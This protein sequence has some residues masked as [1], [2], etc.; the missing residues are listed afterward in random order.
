MEVLMPW[1][2]GTH[3]KHQIVQIVCDANWYGRTYIHVTGVLDIFEFQG[4]QNDEEARALEIDTFLV[5]Q[6]LTSLV[7]QKQFWSSKKL[8]K[9]FVSYS[10][11]KVSVI[12]FAR[13]I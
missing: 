2:T 3:P 11:P 10:T 8:K 1:C 13:T 4:D 6:V 5:P 12:M 9:L 7:N